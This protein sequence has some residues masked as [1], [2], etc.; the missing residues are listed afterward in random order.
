M[1]IKTNAYLTKHGINYTENFYGGHNVKILDKKIVKFIQDNNLKKELLIGRFGLEKENLRV[2]YDGKLALTPHPKQ[3]GQKIKNLY[4]KTDFSESQVE[5]ITP[6]FRTLEESYD[7]LE[8]LQNIVSLELDGELLWPQSSPSI[9]VDEKDIPIADFGPLD[10]G[11]KEYRETLSK[12]YGKKNQLISGIH[13]NFSFSDKLLK[14]LHYEFGKN[15]S[16]KDF[17]NKVY[18]K[19]TKGLLQYRWLAM[20]LTGASPIVHNTYD[21]RCI[22][23][24][25]S[26]DGE[27]YFLKDNVSFRNGIYGYKNKKDYIIPYDNVENYVKAIKG[28]VED[29]EIS[30]P[31][32]FY[33][34]VRLRA[35]DN[36][37]LLNSLLSDGISYLEIRYIDLNPFNKN[38]ID[39]ETL[40]L[41]HLFILYS[42][43]KEDEEFGEESQKVSYKNHELAVGSGLKKNL[44]IYER[45]DKKVPLYKLGEDILN[46][47][48][49]LIDIIG[50]KEEFLNQI[51]DNSIR[52]VKNPEET[53][54]YKVLKESENKKYISFHL[55]KA[56]EYLEESKKDEFR[57]KG[58]EDLELSTQ[59]LLKDAIK[60]GVNYEVLDRLDNFILLD[61]GEKKEYIKQATKTSLD[62]YSTVMVMENKVVTKK[63]LDK[64]GIRVPSGKDYTDAFKA[65]EDFE[66]FQGKKIV[67]KPKSTNFGIGITIFKD[68]FTKESYERAVD[69]AFENDSSVLVEEFIEGKEYRF[70]VIGENVEGVLNRVPANV[71]GDGKRTILELVE[72]KNKDFLRG[73]GYTTPLEKINLGE[74]EEMFLESQSKNFD[75]VPLKDEVIYLRENS[76]ISTGGDSIDFT[77]DIL[78]EYKE[79]AIK[80][81]KAVGAVICGVDMMIE[82]IKEKPTEDNYGIIELNFNPAI[83]IHC[84]PYKGKNRKLGD[85]ILD[86][87]NM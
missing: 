39:L 24:M 59:I 41:I 20:Y 44:E 82:N 46:E 63:V 74:A 25:E 27:N 67:I 13:Y 33:S 51:I 19:V 21:E 47:V 61:N 16:F 84:Y 54:A 9:L 26:N 57:L 58:Y 70:I 81:A 62:T 30:D 23:T 5:M 28:L 37:D 11:E 73:K 14:K 17:K 6:A 53:I 32:E 86:L 49:K 22:N 42:L 45:L 35:K 78:D 72:E 4:I 79:I 36:K 80:S 75:Y 83:H 8:N 52:K 60:R 7:F 71:M 64:E 56:K 1:G 29:G 69:I 12:K 55:N 3:F 38:G 18:L 76:N 2:G 48:R 87:L 77:D 50:Q 15:T 34:S 43:I 31:R 40:Y 66:L 65:K 10:T 85:K 68:K